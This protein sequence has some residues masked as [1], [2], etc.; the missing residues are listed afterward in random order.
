[1]EP[2]GSLP[3]SQVPATCPYPQPAR[4][5]PY[6]TSHFLK[7][8]LNIIFHSTPGSPKWS[9]S[10]RFP[11]Q[12]PVYDSPL[13][14]MC[15]SSFTAEQKERGVD[16]SSTHPMNRPVKFNMVVLQMP[17]M[18]LYCKFCY[19]CFQSNTKYVQFLVI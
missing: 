9:L 4:S 13:L 7:I 14:R 8:P 11:H 18:H 15:Y 12:N 16:F 5:S 3:H 2:K 6:P 19:R 17:I 1:M 10:L